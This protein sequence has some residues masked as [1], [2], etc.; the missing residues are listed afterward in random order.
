MQNTSNYY[1]DYESGYNYYGDLNEMADIVFE[2]EYETVNLPKLR[3]MKMLKL[4]TDDRKMYKGIYYIQVRGADEYYQRANKL[5]SLSDIGLIVKQGKDNVLVYANSIA[6]AR[7]MSGLKLNLVSNNNQVMATV[8]TNSEGIAVVKDLA[9][10]APGFRLAMITATD[11]NDFNYIYLNNSRTDLSGYDV[12]GMNENAPGLQAFI[13]GDRDLYRPGETIHFNTVIRNSKWEPVADLPVKIKILLPNGNEFV[14]IRKNL[15]AQGAVTTDIATT[16]SSVTGSYTIEVFSGNDVL[17]QSKS[18]NIEEFMPDRIKV[19]LSSDK[20]EYK[21]GETIKF[22][23]QADNLFGT[24]A[25]NRNYKTQ[26]SFSNQ[27][28]S[29]KK[30]RDYNFSISNGSTFTTLDAEGKTDDNGKATQNIV[31]PDYRDMGLLQ[32]RVFATVFD[33]N[34]RPVNRSKT[35]N[36]YTQDVF[37]GLNLSD[38]YYDTQKPHFFRPRNLKTFLGIFFQMRRLRTP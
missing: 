9:K 26:A 15:N 38:Y 22:G 3:N 13:Y 37:Y 2:K 35:Y 27:Y 28:F 31:I 25:T 24:P 12:A 30:F 1:G 5:V 8:S 16:S 17:L 36:I 4:N 20:E 21:P 18:I 34:G 32:A 19:S 29:S 33:E 14:S 23:I 10:L 11:G 6:T 7:A